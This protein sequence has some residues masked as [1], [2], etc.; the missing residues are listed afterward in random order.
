MTSSRADMPAVWRQPSRLTCVRYTDAMSIDHSSYNDLELG[1]KY[2]TVGSNG[3]ALG[4]SKPGDRV[5]IVANR[6]PKKYFTI[7]VI[8]EPVHDCRVWA[9]AG[10]HVWNN[11]FVYVPLIGL[12]EITAAVTSARDTIA[13]KHCLNANN[14]FHSRFCSAKLNRLVDDLLVA[15]AK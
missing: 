15:L 10:G 4:A 13:T 1:D 6:G 2:R 9:D 14:L 8:Q 7:G 11:N 3:R 5:I 12:Q